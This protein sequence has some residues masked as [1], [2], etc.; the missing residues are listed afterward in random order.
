MKMSIAKKLI[1]SI[2]LMFVVIM[3]AVSA[4]FYLFVSDYVI[5]TTERVAKSYMVIFSNMVDKVLYE[6]GGDITDKNIL[7]DLSKNCNE[8]CDKYNIDYIYVFEP[9]FDKNEV[10]YYFVASNSSKEHTH[11]DK[12]NGT[13]TDAD[14]GDEIRSVWDGE[15][16]IVNSTTDNKYG[17]ELN[18]VMR[19]DDYSD[20]RVLVAFDISF[21]NIYNRINFSFVVFLAI[22]LML[23]LLMDIGIYFIIRRNVVKPAKKISTVMNEF[24]LNGCK[25][26]SSLQIKSGYEF[27]VIADSYNK[28]TENINSYIH[29]IK[30]LTKENEK[31]NASLNIAA[32]IQRGLL[33]KEIDKDKA[34]EIS[35]MM[36]PARNVGGDLYDYMK[37]DDERVLLVVADVSGKGV[38]AAMF[39][40]MTLTLIRQYARLGKSVSEILY[41]ANNALCGNNPQMLFVTVFVAIY[42][43][44]DGKLVYANAGHN[45]PYIIGKELKILDDTHC[46][47]I[48]MFEDEKYSESEISIDVGDILFMYTDG[49]NEAISNDLN[50]YGVDRLE[51]CL[52]KYKTT[53]KGSVVEYVYSSVS[54]FAQG[55]EQSDDITMLALL[56]RDKYELELKAEER[57]FAKIRQSIMESTIPKKLRLKLCLACEEWF[58][59][60]CSY[61]F[62]NT[63]VSDKRVNFRIE[64]SD[65]IL[66]MF[67]DNGRKYNPLEDVVTPEEY[68]IE[69]QIGGLGKLIITSIADEIS[70]E[71]ADNKNILTIIK[72]IQEEE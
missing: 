63:D 62:K 54:E 4:G 22:L 57:D 15:T 50:L 1:L 21:N 34:F 27:S 14:L 28:M 33:P 56:A 6:N 24:V 70:Y 51:K 25:Q 30:A 45:Y 36:V 5:S 52:K 49:V 20:N 19:I 42:N 58:V 64:V 12:K 11:A 29:D 44:A 7:D 68:D 53:G 55:A 10:T 23:M 37:L 35:A 59:N 46:V 38:S 65:K 69:N 17:N 26:E 2:T 61:G 31:I 66:I 8:L 41:Y 18:T 47:P 67:K 9:D 71:Y 3:I 13:T 48:G 72:Y 40:S 60:I 39:M 43:K 16:D 32:Q